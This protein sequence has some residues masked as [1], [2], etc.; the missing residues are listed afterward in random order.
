[1]SLLILKNR[2]LFMIETFCLTLSS[3]FTTKAVGLGRLLRA[4]SLY[5]F[6]NSWTIF[7]FYRSSK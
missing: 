6:H 4:N 1:M 7:S 5:V 3:S 2:D